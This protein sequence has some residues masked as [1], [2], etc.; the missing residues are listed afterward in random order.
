MRLPVA[1]SAARSAPAPVSASRCRRCALW[2]G[3]VQHIRR[4][5]VAGSMATVPPAADSA[6]H[7]RHEATGSRAADGPPHRGDPG[8]APHGVEPADRTEPG[9]RIPVVVGWV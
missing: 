4:L 5:P 8:V 2:I 6:T 3:L 1:E 9:P 7:G